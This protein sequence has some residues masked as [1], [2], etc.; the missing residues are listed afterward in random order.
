MTIDMD[1]IKAISFDLLLLT[2]TLTLNWEEADGI[3]VDTNTVFYSFPKI[4]SSRYGNIYGNWIAVGSVAG[5]ALLS[6]K[7][8]ILNKVHIIYI[9]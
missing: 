4:S 1:L 8:M 9:I 7:V 5:L 6:L 3:I 2:S